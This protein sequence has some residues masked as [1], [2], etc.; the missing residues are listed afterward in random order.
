MI[1]ACP[2][3]LNA[4]VAGSLTMPSNMDGSIPVKVTVPAV[5]V[6][7]APPVVDGAIPA[8]DKLLHLVL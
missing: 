8:K 5:G 3:K 7:T 4:P 2:V 6:I 1:G